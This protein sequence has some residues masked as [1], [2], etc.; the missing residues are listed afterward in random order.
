MFINIYVYMI[1]Y[2]AFHFKAKVM[3]S[4]T[5]GYSLCKSTAVVALENDPSLKYLSHCGPDLSAL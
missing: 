5:Y 3:F 2:S 1:C 4:L